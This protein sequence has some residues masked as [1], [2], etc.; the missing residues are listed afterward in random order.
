MADQL[1]KWPDSCRFGQRIPKEK[2]Y[3]NAGVNTADR[4]R[5]VEEVNKIT[6]AYKLADHTVNLPASEEIAELVIIEMDANG[7]D[8]SEEVLAII[9]KAISHPVIFEINR[10][11]G[12]RRQTR[13][14][15]AHKQPG[16]RSQKLS[17]YF[18]TDW[19]P[20][21]TERAPLPPATNLENQYTSL[22]E[23]LSKVPVLPGETL[24]SVAERLEDIER[25]EREI[26]ALQRKQKNEKQFNRRVELLRVIKTKQKQ[27]D[28]LR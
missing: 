19:Q 20:S 3:Q 23:S 5:F 13:M 4:K 11:F 28:A 1:F 9:D 10:V 25:L 24:S 12:H 8:V 22:L 26:S 6:W 17:R 14:V 27:L 21:E 7:H 18:S 16:F 15:A 2:I